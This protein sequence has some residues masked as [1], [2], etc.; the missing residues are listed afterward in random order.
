MD[1]LLPDLTLAFNETFQ[2]LSIST[3]LAILGGLPLGF[4]IFVT[5]RHLFWQN[6]FIYLVASVLVNI[7]RSVPF[8]ILLVLLLPLTQLLLGNTIGPIAA[9]VP[10]SVAAIAFYAR[11]VDSALREVDKGIIEAALAF[12][13]SPMRIICTVLLPEAS[14]GLL[15]GLTITLV[16][17]IGYSAMA[18]IVGGGGGVGDLA[19]RYGYYRYETEVMVVTVVALIV[20][21]QVVQMLGDWLA[22]RADKRDRH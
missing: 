21:V 1:D 18:G 13:A 11:L 3:V 17:L 8:V 16:S 20:L 12:G 2:M 14:A 5:D 22:K 10:L 9:S 15:R 7:I 19:I 4:L 6:R